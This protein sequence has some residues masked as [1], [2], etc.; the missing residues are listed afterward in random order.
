MCV[1]VSEEESSECM[2]VWEEGE[3]MQ[4]RN[5]ITLKFPPTDQNTTFPT[6]RLETFITLGPPAMTQ[7]GDGTQTDGA[8]N[9]VLAAP[10]ALTGVMRARPASCLAGR[11][12]DHDWPT[13]WTR[14]KWAEGQLRSVK[15]RVRRSLARVPCVVELLL[16]GEMSWRRRGRR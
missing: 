11:Q 3:Y 16:R 4:V 6:T 9:L 2:C 10:L 5:A 13:P 8:R 14:W 15:F 7:R 12:C 1:C